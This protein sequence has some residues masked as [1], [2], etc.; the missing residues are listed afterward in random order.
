MRTFPC[1]LSLEVQTT[2]KMVCSRNQSKLKMAASQK[3][4]W[5]P[6]QT[7]Q[8]ERVPEDY[9]GW[10]SCNFFHHRVGRDAW[11]CL[12]VDVIPKKIRRNGVFLPSLQNL[13]GNLLL[14]RF[15]D[16]GIRKNPSWHDGTRWNNME[17]PGCS[18]LYS[19]A[20][21][22]GIPVSQERDF[23]QIHYTHYI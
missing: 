15:F 23:H 1:R 20:Y 19:Q 14:R 8:N 10:M 2:N 7:P 16:S 5:N 22:G 6:M 13:K 4:R 18:L 9:F 17:H 11:D 3:L 21:L 12:G